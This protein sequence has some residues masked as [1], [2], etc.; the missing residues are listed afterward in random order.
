ML[1]SRYNRQFSTR[2]FRLVAKDNHSQVEWAM[3][4]EMKENKHDTQSLPD[5]GP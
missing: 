3:A 2:G 1:R 4:A 5:A